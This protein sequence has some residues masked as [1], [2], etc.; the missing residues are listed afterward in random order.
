MNT[1]LTPEDSKRVADAI[2]HMI[3]RPNPYLHDT[4]GESISKSIRSGVEKSISDALFTGFSGNSLGNKI[5][6][7]VFA[8]L[9]K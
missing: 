6:E 8:A 2:I 1:L 4:L 5:I 9:K 3:Q 7:M